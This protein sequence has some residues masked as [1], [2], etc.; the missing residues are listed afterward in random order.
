MKGC[1]QDLTP[2]VPSCGWEHVIT[3]VIQLQK[4]S[5]FNGRPGR[6]SVNILCRYSI[7]HKRASH[8]RFDLVILFVNNLFPNNNSPVSA[9]SLSRL[10][11]SGGCAWLG[12]ATSGLSKLVCG[13]AREST[14]R[15]AG[16]IQGTVSTSDKTSFYKI[17]RNLVCVCIRNICANTWSIAFI[18]GRRLDSGDAETPVKYKI[19]R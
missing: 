18:F 2:P 7:K 8:A 5:Q 4:P 9:A 14:L 1:V 17:S 3:L 12:R 13:C 6:F 16:T 19:I 11:K 15:H 10:L